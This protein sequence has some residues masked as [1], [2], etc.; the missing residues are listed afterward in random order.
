MTYADWLADDT[1]AIFLLHGVVER[2]DYVVRNYTRKHLAAEAFDSFLSALCRQGQ[3]LSLDEVIAF[4]EDSAP[5]PSRSF[6]VTFDDGFENNLSVAAP[7]LRKHR[8]PTTFYITTGFVGT[9]RMSWIDR[10]EW[11]FESVGALSVWLPWAETLQNAGDAAAKIALL[12][13]IRK[14]VKTDPELDPDRVASDVQTQLGLAETHCATGPLDS[15]LTWD[16]V[17]ELAGDPLFTVGGHSHT[18]AVLSFL[19]PAALDRELDTSLKLLESEAGVSARHY[20]YPEGLAHCYSL[21]VIE[22]LRRRGVVCCPT[23]EP[24]NNDKTVDL[25]H[26]KRIAVT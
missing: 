19:D 6:A 24:G 15:K 10:I 20:S 14:R 3:P 1:L 26:L 12:D 11:A 23:A 17:R 4:R 2:S 5:Y 16:Q 7:L 22:A 25:F 21:A 9:N 8:V 13:E 18:H